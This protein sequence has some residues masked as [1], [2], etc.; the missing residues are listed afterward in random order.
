MPLGKKYQPPL[1]QHRTIYI[2]LNLEECA[3]WTAPEQNVC[4]NAEKVWK[5]MW[6]SQAD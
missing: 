2:P 1:S 6:I 5:N 4:C 3:V